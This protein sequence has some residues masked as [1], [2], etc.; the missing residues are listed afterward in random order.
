MV[1]PK[2]Y[3]L[4][5]SVLCQIKAWNILLCFRAYDK[6]VE[7]SLTFQQRKLIVQWCYIPQNVLST[8]KTVETYISN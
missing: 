7:G 4:L 2:F 3:V 5:S 6:M 8:L 1:E